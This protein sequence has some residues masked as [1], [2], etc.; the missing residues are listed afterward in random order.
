MMMNSV[1]EIISAVMICL[2]AFFLFVGG[3]GI[4]RLPDFYTRSHAISKSDTLGIMMILAGLA[5]YEGLTLN[6]LKLVIAII[7]VA[8]A[9]PAG[10]H[11]LARA[12]FRY[13][14]R[15]WPWPWVRRRDEKVD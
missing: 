2:G 9:N 13:G 12:G 14:L 6:S 5:V 11:A 7:F 3:L 15:P 4:I 8:I 1:H 10:T